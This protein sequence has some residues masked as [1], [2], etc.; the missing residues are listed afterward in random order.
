MA[1]LKVIAVADLRGDGE[2]QT[3]ASLRPSTITEYAERLRDGE[4]PPPVDA[5]FDGSVYWLADG[6]HRREAHKREGKLVISARVHD[7]SRH[8]ALMFSVASHNGEDRERYTNAD[9]RRAVELVLA[10]PEC[11]EMSTR[12]I[13]AICRCHHTLVV[14][15]RAETSTTV[16]TDTAAAQPIG[17]TPEPATTRPLVVADSARDKLPKSE[18]K[19][20]A[21]TPARNDP[22]SRATVE[23]RAKVIEM[24]KSL[25]TQRE[26]AA[27]IGVAPTVISR[28]FKSLKLGDHEN[29]IARLSDKAFGDAA[30][31]RMCAESFQSQWAEATAAQRKE[32]ISQLH[33]V[34]KTINQFIKRLNKEA[35]KR[36][37]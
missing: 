17:K 1:E 9:K 35:D 25:S 33:D 30:H 19:P 23:R 7:G 13:G 37:A 15:M 24:A 27:A 36:T 8:D 6:F 31:W 18:P 12:E 34:T 26:I 28:D 3:R 16:V 21:L 4:V 29:P 11:A 20:V 10:D 5:F 32:L 14:K 22:R 2:T